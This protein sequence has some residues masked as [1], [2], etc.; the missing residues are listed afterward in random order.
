MI[1]TQNLEQK[2]DRRAYKT[3]RLQLKTK[4]KQIVESNF[5]YLCEQTT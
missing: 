4:H 1:E 5:G 2:K 3:E